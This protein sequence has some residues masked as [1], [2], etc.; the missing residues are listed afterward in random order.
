MPP[1]P[2]TVNEISERI[3]E[4]IAEAIAETDDARRRGLLELADLWADIR[5]SRVA[6][7]PATRQPARM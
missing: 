4:L 7:G 6:A 3:S 2:K 5:R 1:K